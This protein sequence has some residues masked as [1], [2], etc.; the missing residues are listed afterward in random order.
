MLIG[1]LQQPYKI[2]VLGV[3]QIQRV[4]IFS[5]I[6][7]H[8][9]GQLLYL[10]LDKGLKRLNWTSDWN[11]LYTIKYQAVV[12]TEQHNFE[13]PMPGKLMHTYTVRILLLA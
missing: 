13:I 5:S 4:Y 9:L 1:F 8:H 6:Y 11:P 7:S 3:S 12:Y 2:N 10:E